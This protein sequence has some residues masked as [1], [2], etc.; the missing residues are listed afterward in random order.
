[1]PRSRRDHNDLL[2]GI[3]DSR[4]LPE[5]Q[6]AVQYMHYCNVS[7]AT[8]HEDLMLASLPDMD[9]QLLPERWGHRGLS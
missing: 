5:S 6:E 4:N 2:E 9:R 1:M 7:F 8:A 3:C